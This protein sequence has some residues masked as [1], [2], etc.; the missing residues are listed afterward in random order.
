[1]ES[2]DSIIVT[3]ACLVVLH[4]ALLGGVFDRL[5]GDCSGGRRVGLGGDG[6]QLEGIEERAG[7][8]IRDGQEMLEGI[9][10]EVRVE[11]AEAAL[12]VGKGRLHYALKVFGLERLEDDDA[13]AREES[14]IDLEGWVFSCGTNQGHGAVFYVGKNGV[15]LALV[16][17][18]YFV[19]EEN[20]AATI[21]ES[22]GGFFDDAA[23]V[24]DA[25]RHCANGGKVGICAV[26][27]NLGN[28]GLSAAGRSPENERGEAI[29]FDGATERLTRGKEVL[30][31]DNF[32]EG[33]R[34]HPGCEGDARA[35]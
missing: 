4:P 7:I 35:G 12:F 15:L 8:A 33:T 23:K 6:G 21:F 20:G 27:D 9:V 2:G 31:A 5:N 30:L 28:G 22:F 29:C 18:V 26:G 11:S 17:A 13:G 32:V 1:V 3:I 24:G 10:G 19:Y 16:E 34:A 25:C 14:R